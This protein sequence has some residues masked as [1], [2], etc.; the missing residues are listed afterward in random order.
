[1]DIFKEVRMNT[2]VALVL[3]CLTMSLCANEQVGAKGPACPPYSTTKKPVKKKVVPCSYDCD[4]FSK[5]RKVYFTNLEFLYWTVNESALDYAIK[6]KNPAWG[7]PTDAVGHYKRAEFDWGPGFRGNIGFFNAPHY[8][9]AQVQYTYFFTS[10]HE[11]AKAPKA[12]NLFL[13]G[14]WPQPD[15]SGTVPLA[16]A[17]SSI[18]LMMNLIDLIMTRRF[19]PN[20]HLRIRVNAGPTI[21]WIRQNWEVNYRDT[22]G[23]KSHLHN[24]WNFMGAGLQLGSIIDWFMGKGGYYITAGG[25]LA[26]LGGDYHNVTKQKSNFAG[27]GF[28]PSLPLRN[29]HYQD[30]RL[31]PH[32][33]IYAGPSWQQSYDKIRT[34][35][36]IGYEF[37]LWA[38]LHEVIRTSSDNPRGPKLTSLDSGWL[39][40]QGITLR[41][42][43]DF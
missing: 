31:I 4:L 3:S 10:G 35:V 17:D 20:P 24:H 8:W 37:N 25:S 34:E 14:T 22:N 2:K 26:F 41:W 9:D 38:N 23:N 15:P 29:A 28:N 21:A 19:H 40:L 7:N 36:F 16:H 32:F 43:L 39:G 5:D 13:N 27:A 6:M 33:Q 12:D 30:I 42:N 1:M 18:K 11:N